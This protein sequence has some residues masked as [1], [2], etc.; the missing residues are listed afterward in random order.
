V[1]T[2]IW[3][4]HDD[5]PATRAVT[6]PT[7]LGDLAVRASA[8]TGLSFSVTHPADGVAEVLIVPDRPATVRAAW[9]LPCV[10][11]VAFWVPDSG[12]HRGL[13]PFW[14]RPRRASLEKG[15]PAGALV[16]TGD[17]SLC[18]YAVGEAERP[19]LIRTGVVE[20]TGEFGF[21]AEHAASPSAGLRLRLD[22]SGRHF[23]DTLADVAA[24]WRPP[25]RPVP[26][27]ARLPAYSTWYTM[28]QHVTAEAV[29]RQA[30]LAA[31]LGCAA[32][33]VDDG[34][35]SD[36]RGRGYA[37]VGEWEPTFADPAAHVA[38]VR[39][40]GLAYLLWYA[41]PFVGRHTRL[42]ERVRPYSLAYRPHM[43]AV[44]V[45]PR[46]PHIRD[47]LAGNVTRAV[48]EWGADGLK[49][50]F[51]DQFAVEDPPEPGPEADC[52]DVTEGV[53][54][55][56]AQI[57]AGLPQDAPIE[58]RQPYT[59]PGLRPHATMIRASDCPLS[60]LHNRQR[61]VDLRLVAGPV[62]VHSDMLMWHPDE[63]PEQVAAQLLNVLFSVPQISVDLSAQSP[64]H[65][66]VL[67]F[68]LAF[69]REHAG[70][71]QGGRFV[72][73][74]PDLHYPLVSAYGDG[75]AITGRYGDVAVPVPEGAGVWWLA[76][77]DASTGVLLRPAPGTRAESTV[78]DCRGRQVAEADLD[79]AGV[80]EIEVPTGG[81]LRLVTPG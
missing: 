18:T 55:L 44:V 43:N 50:D 4:P 23:A 45:D 16:G 60:P 42:W 21:W 81:L 35:H 38:R 48:R 47:L 67:R 49:I 73:S 17:R 22:R 26:L 25:A 15:A 64:A 11:A 65:L 12:E 63:S 46:Y 37:Y 53:R 75:V 59:S 30:A 36:D 78:Y 72:P 52:A 24:W 28:Q 77:A 32:I 9:R 33:I 7:G 20:E 1:T 5:A 10:D 40:K 66:E 80:R 34:W 13:P 39:E 68:W 54:R 56:M 41:L 2:A 29:E 58:L 27:A 8:S 76:N 51:I 31:E 79:L 6:V 74:R 70:V 69:F 71:L 61:T 19:V 3:Q 57:S 62:A 14:R